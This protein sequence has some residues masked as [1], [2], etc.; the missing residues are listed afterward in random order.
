MKKLWKFLIAAVAILFAVLAIGLVGLFYKQKEITQWAITEANKNFEGHLQVADSQVSIFHDFPYLD[1]DLKGV[2]FFATK[3][4]TTQ[5]LYEINDLY[6]GFRWLDLVQSNFDVQLIDVKGGHVDVVQ[7]AN[8]D[9]N[10]L[11]AKKISRDTTTSNSSNNEFQVHLKKLMMEDFNISFARQIDS[12]EYRSHLRKVQLSLKAKKGHLELKTNTSLVFTF[13]KAGQPTFFHDKNVTF[14]ADVDFDSTTQKL[15]ITEG[16][17]GLEEARFSA[18]GSLVL[19]Q[20][21]DFDLMVKGEK[22]DFTLFTS[23]APPEAASIINQYSNQGKVF[24]EGTIRGKATKEIQPQ[25]NFKFGCADGLVQNVKVKKSIDQLQITGSFTNGSERSLRTSVFELRNFSFRPDRGEFKGNLLMRDFT[26]PQ[27]AVSLTSNLDLDF[28]A[29]FLQI[30]QIEKLKGNVQLNMNFNELVDI[31]APENSLVRL[32]EGIESELIVKDLSFSLPKQ[33]IKID[34]INA[35]AQ[36]KEG[37]FTLDSLAIRVG[38]SDI[39]FS[40]MVSDLPALFHKPN[41][42]I[43]MR[44]NVKGN[45]LLLNELATADTALAKSIDEE[46]GDYEV[47]LGF[48]TSVAKLKKSPLPLGEFY[49]DDLHAKLKGYPHTLHDLRA[50]IIITDSSFQMKDFSGQIDQSDFHFNGK[51]VNYALWFDSIKRGDTRFEFDFFS[52]QLKLHNLLTYKG[53]S[54]LPK[55]YQDEVIKDVRLHGY[56][57]LYFNN[58]FKSADLLISKV[59]GKLRV[60]PLKIE[61]LKGRIHFEDEHLTVQNLSAKMGTSDFNI[62]LAFYAGKNQELKKRDNKFSI[63]SGFLNLDELLNFD[64]EQPKTSADHAKA[65][66]IFEIPFTDMQFNAEIGKIKHHHILLEQMTAALRMQQN[67]YLYF[68]T[69]QFNTAGGKLAMKGYFNG[70]DPKKIYLKSNSKFEN[71]NLDQLLFKF[72]NFG[73][74]ALVS[75]NLHGQLTGTVNSMIRVHP[76]LTPI[77]NEGEAHMDIQ[78]LNGSLNNFAPLQ[79]MA[80]YF[81]DK[82]INRVRFDTLQNTLDLK[83]GVLN[84]PAMTINSSLG[85]IELQGSQSLDLKMDYLIRIPWKL[86][87]QV[88]VRALFGGKNKEEVDPEQVDAIQYRENDKRVRFLNVRVKGTPD[89]FDFSLGKK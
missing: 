72:D 76:D 2:R 19:S 80:G 16:H 48:T 57:D 53:E 28:L 49:V 24:F 11:M 25:I 86:V 3:D 81:K 58:Q 61:Q 17:L 31:H 38:Q 78:I 18:F 70:S 41:K 30:Q 36:M 1:L 44:L 40:G 64:L 88:G 52:Q 46:L 4:T 67:H 32:K 54:Y 34:K 50:D 23:L 20:Q 79:A 22:P 77:L 89:K 29:A 43:T 26:N 8:G 9:I 65:F 62:N 13:L 33:S 27:V 5:P 10:I 45:R 83:N 71:M 82:N 37:K 73:Q 63:Q 12:T 85:F 74:D 7:Y 87:T 51:L 60:H 42:D 84:I 59:E 68:D 47:K 56:T 69:I 35:H 66:N 14:E 55:D 15:N 21:P 6:L 75:N 39:S